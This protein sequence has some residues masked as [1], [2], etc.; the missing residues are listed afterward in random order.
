MSGRTLA[1]A[2]RWR[3]WH[4]A[5]DGRDDRRGSAAPS[6]TRAPG[7]CSLLAIASSGLTALRRSGGGRGCSRCCWRRVY[8]SRLFWPCF[9]PAVGW[10]RRRSFLAAGCGIRAWRLA[11]ARSCWLSLSP[12][13][14]F[15]LAYV[16]PW[17][18]SILGLRL[19]LGST[20][21]WNL[22]RCIRAI[23]PATLLW[24]ASF[25]LALAA[26]G[27]EPGDPARLTCEVYAAT[28]PGPSWAHWRLV[29]C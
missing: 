13:P 24:G 20:S 1:R 2:G 23:F 7:V 8:T 12:G 11:V 10:Q 25:P 26:A 27:R 6:C 4:G 16:L 15:T 29:C 17:W 22:T 3:Q 14:R 19:V 5:L 9:S 28:P 18:P 21:I